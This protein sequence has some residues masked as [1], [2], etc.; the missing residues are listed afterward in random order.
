MIKTKNFKNYWITESYCQPPWSP[1]KY[2]KKFVSLVWSQKPPYD[3][4]EKFTAVTAGTTFVNSCNQFSHQRFGTRSQG[5]AAAVSLFVNRGTTILSNEN[6]LMPTIELQFW[7]LLFS[8]YYNLKSK[9]FQIWA[10]FFSKRLNVKEYMLLPRICAHCSFYPGKF[11]KLKENTRDLP[12]VQ[13]WFFFKTQKYTN[14]KLY[15]TLRVFSSVLYK[16]RGPQGSRTAKRVRH[17]VYLC[18]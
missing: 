14:S 8:K 10:V 6:L 9:L 17:L 2:H 15:V 13:S 18:G 7:K 11:E 1:L 4:Y 3:C 5:V 16:G 12:H